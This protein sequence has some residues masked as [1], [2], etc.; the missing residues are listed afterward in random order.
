MQIASVVIVAL[1]EIEPATLA[2]QRLRTII[3]KVPILGRA[4]GRTEAE[5]LMAVG[6]TVVIQ[7]EIEAAGTAIRHALAYLDLPTE[8]IL[9]Y[10][11]RFREAED[12]WIMN[13]TPS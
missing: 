1:P 10:Q 6:A 9:D 2:V 7:P 11:E 13:D 12:H 3:A 5:H 4:H 8:R